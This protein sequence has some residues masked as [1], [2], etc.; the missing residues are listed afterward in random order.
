MKTSAK[1]A[2]KVAIALVGFPLLIVGLILIPLPGPGI[3]VSLGALIILSTEFEWAQKYA[4]KCRKILKGVVDKA[5][6]QAEG[7]Q[8]KETKDNVAVKKSVSKP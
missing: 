7:K 1:A 5:K 6:E 8:A 3:L 2:R 4:D